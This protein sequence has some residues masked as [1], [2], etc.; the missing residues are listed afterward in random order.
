[1]VGVTKG[2]QWGERR[3]LLRNKADSTAKGGLGTSNLA[4]TPYTSR[5]RSIPSSPIYIIYIRKVDNVETGLHQRSR[6]PQ[7]ASY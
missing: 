6:R 4:T 1:M 7:V 3:G 2:Q 5:A